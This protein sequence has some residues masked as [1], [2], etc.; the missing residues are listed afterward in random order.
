MPRRAQLHLATLE[1]KLTSRVGRH[2]VASTRSLRAGKTSVRGIPRTANR[3]DAGHA[4]AVSGR[5]AWHRAGAS[6]P[7]LRVPTAS[8]APPPAARSARATVAGASHR[9][10][11][12]TRSMRHQRATPTAAASPGW[13][14]RRARSSRAATT[15]RGRRS[16]HWRGAG[17]LCTSALSTSSGRWRSINASGASSRRWRRAGKATARTSSGV[18]K[19]RPSTAACAAPAAPAPD[20]RAARRRQSR[21]A[22]RA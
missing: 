5:A 14:A 13:P 7:V 22:T 4:G 12:T 15:Q 18:T 17:T 3:R 20:H 6:R 19:S 11:R 16:H 9:S 21:P 2:R 10:P 1:R 8:P